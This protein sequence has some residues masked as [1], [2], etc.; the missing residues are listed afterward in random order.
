MS[1]ADTDKTGWRGS[2]QGE[3][4]KSKGTTG[5]Q[6]YG[7]VWPTNSSGFTALAGGS[8]LPN[9]IFGN[10]VLF[11]TGFWWSL[12]EKNDEEAWYR[13]LDYKSKNIFRYHSDKNYGFSIRCRK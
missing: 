4:L 8:R 11:S 2:N 1:S 12:S 10:P 7:D 5:W 6:R 3:Q 13:H 9:A